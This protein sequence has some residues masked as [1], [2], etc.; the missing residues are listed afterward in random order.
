MSGASGEAH[1][2]SPYPRQARPGRAQCALRKGVQ[3][4][5]RHRKSYG[6]AQDSVLNQP[7]QSAPEITPTTAKSIAL[8]AG[9]NINDRVRTARA[10]V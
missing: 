6:S 8:Q 7:R 2:R 3:T 1:R 10:Q 9:W 5:Q 4:D